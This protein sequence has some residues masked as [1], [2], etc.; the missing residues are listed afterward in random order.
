MFAYTLTRIR[1]LQHPM[2]LRF[3]LAILESIDTADQWNTGCRYRPAVVRGIKR[4]RFPCTH[5]GPRAHRQDKQDSQD[6]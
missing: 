6:S 1:L 5:R 2:E 4:L 3:R